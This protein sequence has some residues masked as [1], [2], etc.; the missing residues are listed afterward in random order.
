MQ[1]LI[2]IRIHFN[3]ILYNNDYTLYD[4]NMPYKSLLA[5]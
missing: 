3:N 1:Y 5:N 2:I 4:I